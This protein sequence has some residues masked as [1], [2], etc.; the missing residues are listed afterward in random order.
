MGGSIFIGCNCR[1]EPVSFDASSGQ[2]CRSRFSRTGLQKL[3]ARRLPWTP[4]S[5][6]SERKN[7][8]HL[9]RHV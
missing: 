6:R 8:C 4:D 2:E 1:D 3:L 7:L 5:E 9:E